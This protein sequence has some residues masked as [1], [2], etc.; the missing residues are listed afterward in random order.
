MQN[1]D[2]NM[3]SMDEFELI[4]CLVELMN[5]N[6]VHAYTLKEQAIRQKYVKIIRDREKDKPV[7]YTMVMGNP[8]I[9][10]REKRQ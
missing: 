1:T 6:P 5:G 3:Y 7:Y 2:N 10:T 9:E 8:S 4:H